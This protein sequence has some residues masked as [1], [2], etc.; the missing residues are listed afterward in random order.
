MPGDRTRWKGFR[1][2]CADKT[3]LS[4]PDCPE[5]WKKFGCHK[6]RKHLGPVG[7]EFC[8]LFSVFTRAPLAFAFDKSST[9]E[10]RLFSRLAGHI[11]KGTVLLLDNGFYAFGIFELL[12]ARL[13]HFII[14]ASVSLRPKLVSQIGPGDYLAEIRDSKTRRTMIVRVIYVY[15]RG[16]RRRRIVTSLLDHVKF[17]AA[18]IAALYHLRWTVETFYREFKVNMR[19]NVW[20][21][22][23]TDSFEKELLS[24]LIAVCLVRLASAAS[25]GRED[26]MPCE[27]SFSKILVEVRIFLGKITSKAHFESFSGEYL[28]LIRR[29]CRYLVDVR[30]GRS[31]PRDKQE[32]RRK[33]R[34]LLKKRPG[35]PPTKYQALETQ[36]PELLPSANGVVFLLS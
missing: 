21:C 36:K 14:P 19:A 1:L 22:Q 20:H 28:Q 12:L 5:L 2:V 26:R 15:R 3:T 4:L 34:G 17:P 6:V 10:N 18:E 11:R 7:A 30:P 23:K 32:Y 13:S 27:L 24:K 33:S 9:S 8:C 29:C 16:F 25:S 31:F 35:R